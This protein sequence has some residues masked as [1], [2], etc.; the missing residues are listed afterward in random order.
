M[1]PPAGS[2][3]R[4]FIRLSPCKAG[5]I[6][7]ISGLM[8]ALPTLPQNSLA[9]FATSSSGADMGSTT[10]RSSMTICRQERSNSAAGPLFNGQNV[11]Y[12]ANSY[13]RPARTQNWSFEIQK[14]LTKDLILSLGYVGVKGDY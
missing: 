14:E 10:R 12:I 2:R 9:A 7:R 11:G 1:R 13:G 5:H 4:W 6:L 3:E 8:W